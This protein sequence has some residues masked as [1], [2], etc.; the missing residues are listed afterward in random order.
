[1]QELIILLM[2]KYGYLAIFFLITI[3]NLFPPIPSEVILTMGGFM[4]TYTS[5]SVTGVVFFSTLASLF[6]AIILYYVGKLLNRE[7]LMR[8]ASGKI[9]RLLRLNAADIDNSISWFQKKGT[10]TVLYCR[11]IPILRSLISIPAGMSEM[12]QGTFLLYTTIGSIIWN[13]VLVTLGSILGASWHSVTIVM[14]QYSQVTKAALML[15]C[16]AAVLYLISKKQKRKK[17]GNS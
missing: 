9:G 13:M 6:G 15:T 10:K 4:T 7:R 5:L 11:F 2:N 1:M 8:I 14:K 12:K 16:M 17:A 3:E